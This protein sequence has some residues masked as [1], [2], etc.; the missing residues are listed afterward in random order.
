MARTALLRRWWRENNNNIIILI[1][2]ATF[3]DG[4]SGRNAPLSAVRLLTAAA[5]YVDVC[6]RSFR[7]GGGGGGGT[8]NAATELII[9]AAAPTDRHQPRAPIFVMLRSH[10]F[11]P[12]H[13][14]R[15]AA[16]HSRVT[17]AENYRC[18]Y[19]YP[20]FPVRPDYVPTTSL[21]DNR[22]FRY[23]IVRRFEE[24]A[25]PSSAAVLS[26]SPNNRNHGRG[27]EGQDILSPIVSIPRSH[28]R[29]R[30]PQ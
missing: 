1:S 23:S 6:R 22:R 12:S 9:A 20:V 14:T 2:R 19:V 17:G 18:L 7:S 3:N 10:P 26:P 8:K 5:A 15:T 25:R 21:Y 24:L 29:T 27:V 11:F 16:A 30:P 13:R 4:G 28:A